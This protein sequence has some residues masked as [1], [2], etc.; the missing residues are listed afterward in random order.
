MLV[1]RQ[2]AARYVRILRTSSRP[3]PG[4][5]T[6]GTFYASALIAANLNP[7][8]IQARLCH[9]TLAETMDTYGRLFADTDDLGRAARRPH[10]EARTNGTG[11][12]PERP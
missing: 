5:T 3:G 11:T 7:K 9:A 1:L 8:I 4:S 10:P 2:S 6:S 12:E